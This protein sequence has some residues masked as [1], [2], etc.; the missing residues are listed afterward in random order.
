MLWFEQAVGF[1]RVVVQEG[2][3]FGLKG[4]MRRSGRKALGLWQGAKSGLTMA[5][6]GGGLRRML[7]RGSMDCVAQAEMDGRVAS[8][9]SDVCVRRM[10]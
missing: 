7:E 5:V 9:V 4:L 10:R 2:W 8:Y 6:G 3:M 1:C